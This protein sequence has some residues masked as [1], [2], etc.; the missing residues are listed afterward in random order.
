MRT[1]TMNRKPTT[2]VRPTS[3]GF[4]RRSVAV[5]RGK[6]Q[7]EKGG[8]CES[9]GRDLWERRGLWERREE[10]VGVGSVNGKISSQRTGFRKVRMRWDSGRMGT[11]SSQRRG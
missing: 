4:R 2:A 10:P 6:G 8:V 3:Q 5:E 1:K 7:Q 11:N 9:G